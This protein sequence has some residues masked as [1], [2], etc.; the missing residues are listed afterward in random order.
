MNTRTLT[1]AAVERIRAP[2]SGQIDHFDQGYPGLAVRV[3]YGCAKSW[4]YFYRLF[5]KQ[6]RLTLGRWPSMS[7]P[8]PAR[9]GAT[10]AAMI[11]SI[12][13]TANRGSGGRALS[14]SLA[15]EP[16][17]ARDPLSHADR[18][19]A[20][21][22]VLGRRLFRRLPLRR[23]TRIAVQAGGR[24]GRQRSRRPKSGVYLF[25]G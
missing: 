12:I 17:F 3:S 1:A 8:P 19:A 24:N 2:S 22:A 10:P 15:G 11:A 7:Y 25:R 13:L 9:P 6:K 14:R 5:G 16:A 18:T 4:V 21:R 23:L 20:T